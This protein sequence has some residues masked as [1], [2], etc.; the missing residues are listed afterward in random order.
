PSPEAQTR[1]LRGKLMVFLALVLATIAACF[2][3]EPPAKMSEP[4]VWMHWPEHVLGYTGQPLNPSEA[5]R[6]LL[7]TD[8]EIAK[9]LYTNPDGDQMEAEIVLSG[10]EH[11]SIHRPEICLRGQGWTLH[12]G[13]IVHIPSKSGRLLDVMV[14]DIT[15][16]WHTPQGRAVQQE[17]LYAYFFVSKDAE[18]A[19]HFDR[20][21]ITNLDLLFHNKAHRWAYVIAMAGV[22]GSRSREQ[23][24]DL[25]KRFFQETAPYILKSESPARPS[26]EIKAL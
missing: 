14:L 6:V 25:I 1:S 13:Q 16:P 21:A 12:S 26:T 23:T 15:Q 2:L 10:I 24:L 20:I 9:D 19:K 7:P 17:A 11:R 18:T 8:T 5:E 3:I 4:G 22:N